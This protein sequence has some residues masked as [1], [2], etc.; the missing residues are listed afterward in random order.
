MAKTH[1]ERTKMV[2]KMVH[3]LIPPIEG[4]FSSS[5]PSLTSL[6]VAAAAGLSSLVCATAVAAR[7]P[8]GV[9]KADGARDAEV[10]GRE[11]LMEPET[12]IEF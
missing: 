11:G 5:S 1:R 2:V 9:E 7:E 10:C 4:F 6:A 8:A 3:L 12:G